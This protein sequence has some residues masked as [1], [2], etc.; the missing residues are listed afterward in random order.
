MNKI[1]PDPRFFKHLAEKILE[2]PAGHRWEGE[3]LWGQIDSDK[4]F[5]TLFQL[6]KSG[7]IEDLNEVI[8]E[9]SKHLPVLPILLLGTKLNVD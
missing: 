8:S 9:L 5:N 3:G 2:G 4:T 7:A 1:E 6:Y